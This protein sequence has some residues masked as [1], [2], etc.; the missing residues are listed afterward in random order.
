MTLADQHRQR[1]R[2]VINATLRV[3][4]PKSLTAARRVFR[5]ACPF[6]TYQRWA[7]ACWILEL[8]A[9]LRDLAKL[10]GWEMPRLLSRRGRRKD[11][12]G[13]LMLWGGIPECCRCLI[14][15]ASSLCASCIDC[16][17]GKADVLL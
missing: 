9:T 4:R 11:V 8:N 14:A 3:V 15:S 16:N 13:Q 10:H 2:E 6:P 1:A 12:P 5:E 7:Y 17:Q